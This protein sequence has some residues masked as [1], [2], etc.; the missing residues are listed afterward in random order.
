VVRTLFRFEKKIVGIFTKKFNKS[1]VYKTPSTHREAHFLP[2]PP[3]ELKFTT[4]FYL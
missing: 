1:P 3:K 4:L 2:Y